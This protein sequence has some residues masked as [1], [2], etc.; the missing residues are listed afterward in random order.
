M[1]LLL[2][3]RTD[4][5]AKT[6]TAL[7]AAPKT[8]K[9]MK[10]RFEPRA[11]TIA[12]PTLLPTKQVMYADPQPICRKSSPPK[13]GGRGPNFSL[14]AVAYEAHDALEPED[15][16][17]LQPALPSREPG[18]YGGPSQTITNDIN[19]CYTLENRTSKD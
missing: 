10:Q 11:A 2:A 16:P 9:T 12:P 7:A 5:C 8:A 4:S 19:M 17:D 18:N 1:S 15:A 3:A 14:S 13:H 6:G